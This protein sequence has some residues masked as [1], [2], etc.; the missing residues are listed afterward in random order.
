MSGAAAA[1]R[2]FA[3]LNL[4][5]LL[6]KAALPY[7][8]SAVPCSDVVTKVIPCLDYV[9]GKSNDPSKPCCGGVKQ[10]WDLTKT[11]PDK[12]AVCEC[13]KKQLSPIK[14]D[15]NRIAQLPKKCG[16]SFT[17]PPITPKYDCTTVV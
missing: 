10:L 13:L 17:L 6:S 14:Y 3:F 4:L 11:K 5:L 2:L 9:A 15:P 16:L 7:P 1:T 12:Q 8:V